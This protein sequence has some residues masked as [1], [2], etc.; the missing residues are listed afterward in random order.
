MNLILHVKQCPVGLASIVSDLPIPLEPVTVE[1]VASMPA[2]S[3][4]GPL[5]ET[6]GFQR[7]R[8]MIGFEQSPLDEVGIPEDMRRPCAAKVVDRQPARHRVLH[9]S[10]VV[11][12]SL[13]KGLEAGVGD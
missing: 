3:S 5:K 4:F 7:F 12:A 9:P 8:Y 6:D 10:K 13:V 2:G 11:K 1:L